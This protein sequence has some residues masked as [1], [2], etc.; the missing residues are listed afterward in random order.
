MFHVLSEE[1]AQNILVCLPQDLYTLYVYWDFTGLRNQIVKDFLQR[2]RPEY[3]L[4]VRLCRIEPESGQ[5]AVECEV[6]L[7]QIS[8]G[9][10]YFRQ[11]N[12]AC[13]YCFEIGAKKPDGGFLCFYQTQPV[14]MQ[15][16]GET[17]RLATIEEEFKL[18]DRDGMAIFESL[19]DFQLNQQLF[20]LSSWT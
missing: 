19:D 1:H 8:F 16:S 15:P 12:P 3:Q 2:V 10:Y 6:P 13:T 5:F 20:A 14:R 11:L 7:Q 18:R 17:D 9:N 4:S